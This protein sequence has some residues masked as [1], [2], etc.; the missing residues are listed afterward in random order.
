M[1][2]I[3]RWISVLWVPL[4]CSSLERTNRL[5]PRTFFW[6]WRQS[7]RHFSPTLI[8]VITLLPLP[9]R[10]EYWGPYNMTRNIFQRF[11][12][13]SDISVHHRNSTGILIPPFLSE[14]A[15]RRPFTSTRLWCLCCNQSREL[16]WMNLEWLELKW[17]GTI[18]QKMVAIAW[19]AL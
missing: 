14:T 3:V 1:C 16:W 8:H 18:D 5:I 6:A 10:I 11:R 13:S 9:R 15:E 2:Q 12:G 19:D 4:L 7:L 17:G